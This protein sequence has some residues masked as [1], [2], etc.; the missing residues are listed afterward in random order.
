M[1]HDY[2]GIAAWGPAELLRG[3][4]QLV[5][6]QVAN[7]AQ[8]AQPPRE[9]VGDDAVAGVQADNRGARDSEHGLDVLVDVMPV[10]PEELAVVPQAER[11]MPPRHVMIA[12]HHQ[13]LARAFRMLDE[14]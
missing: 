4:R 6:A 14:R 2:A 8:V 13:D 7:D 3:T 1:H 11:R 10:L 12:W 9:G 5:I